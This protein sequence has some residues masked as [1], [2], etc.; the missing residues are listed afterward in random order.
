MHVLY[1]TV[2]KKTAYLQVKVSLESGR[3]SIDQV[4]PFMFDLGVRL[5]VQMESCLIL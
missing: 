2:T 3:S 4:Y 5:P 1:S